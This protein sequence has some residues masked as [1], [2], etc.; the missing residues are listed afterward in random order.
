MFA[1]GAPVEE[2]KYSYSE[3]VFTL[4]PEFFSSVAP[5]VHTI[6]LTFGQ[7]GKD[8]IVVELSAVSYGNDIAHL[9]DEV[10]YLNFNDYD[11]N[12]LLKDI[13]AGKESYLRSWS[14]DQQAAVKV[15]SDPVF[16]KALN[17][18]VTCASSGVLSFDTYRPNTLYVLRMTFRVENDAPVKELLIKWNAADVNVSWIENG[19]IK[20]AT[21]SRTTLAFDARTKV[22]TWTS[23]VTKP[24]N[25]KDSLI[26]WINP[27]SGDA[28]QAINIGTIEFF[29]T[30]LDDAGSW[31]K[32]NY[33]ATDGTTWTNNAAVGFSDD[34]APLKIIQ[35][36]N[37]ES[38]KYQ[39]FSLM[40]GTRTLIKG[41]DY[42]AEGEYSHQNITLTPE[43]LKTNQGA[44]VLTVCRG[45]D[46]VLGMDGK[47]FLQ[48]AQVTV[49]R[50]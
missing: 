21:D 40:L 25:E 47:L 38:K 18:P 44:A 2:G 1:D 45:R 20:S 34:S 10:G 43:F 28:R 13:M 7:E 11:E 33:L 23:Y 3:N 15:V 8:D 16:G 32:Y 39:R 17:I 46:G 42:T 12:T 50:T 9:A 48:T 49:T 41:R 14:A 36:M 5:G 4:K 35:N 26:L 29:E 31:G 22:Y 37:D 27:L 24:A 19:D 6:F 30:S